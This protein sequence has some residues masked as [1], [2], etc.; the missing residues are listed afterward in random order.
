MGCT[1]LKTLSLKIASE[2]EKIYQSQAWESILEFYSYALTIEGITIISDRMI[3]IA[4]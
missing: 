4:T 2:R 3:I 1:L